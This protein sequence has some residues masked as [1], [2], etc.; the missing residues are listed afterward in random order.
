MMNVSGRSQASRLGYVYCT[1]LFDKE[2]SDDPESGRTE[3][4]EEMISLMSSGLESDRTSR[5]SPLRLANVAS[6]AG[7]RRR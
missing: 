1:H 2:S 4:E 7:R 6:P 3:E 5:L